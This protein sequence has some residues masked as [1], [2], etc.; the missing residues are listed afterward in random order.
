M[1]AIH[2][3]TYVCICFTHYDAADKREDVEGQHPE[4]DQ[5]DHDRNEHKMVWPLQAPLPVLLT[6]FSPR[7]GWYCG[8][9]LKGGREGCNR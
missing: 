3:C 4:E 9:R 8:H 2:G 7:R 1:V 6:R 5:E